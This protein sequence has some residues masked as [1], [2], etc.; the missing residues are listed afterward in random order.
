MRLR[1]NIR[2]NLQPHRSRN[3][4]CALNSR[5]L[6]KNMVYGSKLPGTPT[7][8]HMWAL[9]S[10]QQ[11][12]AMSTILSEQFPDL[13]LQKPLYYNWESSIRFEI[14]PP[15][16]SLWKSRENALLNEEYFSVALHRATEIFNKAFS[17][18]D[19][20]EIIHQRFSD[21]RQ[22]LKKNNFISRHIF[23]KAIYETASEKLQ[24]IY[25]IEYKQHHWHRLTYS[26][27][28]TIDIDCNAILQASINLDFSCRG[29]TY[30]GECYFIN[31]SKGIILHIY[32][33][34]G[35]DVLGAE[36]CS[37]KSLYEEF[38]QWILDYNRDEIDTVFT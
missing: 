13:K 7:A 8:P 30:I 12:R 16:V 27:L 1:P 14:G 10:L 20:I 31:K 19:E 25:E 15:E 5:A 32:D 36:K 37:I 21:G 24:N 23:P 11:Y 38:N 33:D 28:R 34:R 2:C 29:E 9:Y 3:I 18:D 26:N 4:S 17:P 22:K 6:N 35:M